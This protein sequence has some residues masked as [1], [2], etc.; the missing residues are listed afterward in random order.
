[1]IFVDNHSSD[2]SVAWVQRNFPQVKVIENQANLGFTKANNQGLKIYHGKYALLLNT[3]TVVKDEALDKMVEFMDAHP[4][5]GACGPKLL[6]RDSSIQAEGGSFGKK[7]WLSKVP[8]RVNFVIGACLMVRRET[9]DKVGG[10]DESFFFAN[11]DIDW[12]LSIR[13]AGW[14]VYF[15]PQAEVLHYGG[16][17]TKRYEETILVEGFRG[18]LYFAKKHYGIFIYQIYRFFLALGILILIPFNQQKRGAYIQIL[19]ICLQGKI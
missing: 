2:G 13:K 18:G 9:I 11:D 10:M 19:K 17:T 7:F 1:M 4:K 15:L 12:C 3:D 8:T 16:F 14:E 5:A 6:N